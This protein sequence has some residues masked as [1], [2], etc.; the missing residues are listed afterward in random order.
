MKSI[1]KWFL[2]RGVVKRTSTFFRNS[3]RAFGIGRGIGWRYMRR[4]LALQHPLWKIGALAG[5]TVGVAAIWNRLANEE[6]AAATDKARKLGIPASELERLPQAEYEHALRKLRL[7]VE[8]I[9][10]G[11]DRMDRVHPS[12]MRVVHA[13]HEL[14][15]SIPDPDIAAFACVADRHVGQMADSGMTFEMAPDDPTTI[16]ALIKIKDNGF[17]AEAARDSILRV[18]I[19][20]QADVPLKSI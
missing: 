16:K 19:M 17:D 1:L 18:L 8:N 4:A 15:H 20:D 13:Y 5:A 9:P 7:A 14:L 10:Y 12:I 3:A 2:A 11:I 6:L